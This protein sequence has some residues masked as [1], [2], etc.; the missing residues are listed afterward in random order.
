M[1]PRRWHYLRSGFRWLCPQ[2]PAGVDSRT[3]CSP[4]PCSWRQQGCDPL[5]APRT[6]LGWS[7]TCSFLLASPRCWLSPG[8]PQTWGLGPKAKSALGTGLQG[9]PVLG[10]GPS[11]RAS[12][13]RGLPAQAPGPRVLRQGQRRPQRF[14]RC[15]GRQRAEWLNGGGG[16]SPSC[17]ATEQSPL[18]GLG[19]RGQSRLGPGAA[20]T[21][22]RH[23]L[24]CDGTST[25]SWPRSQGC[26]WSARGAARCGGGAGTGRHRGA[27]ECE[28]GGSLQTQAG[29]SRRWR[30]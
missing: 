30:L 8:T 23:R 21:R 11:T 29:R 16:L 12:G 9:M 6:A 14:R 10:A 7:V 5:E 18:A 2:V 19:Q 28:P 1:F 4:W 20:G 26:L 15:S 25:H 13:P 24:V 3:A 17:L 27:R 22:G